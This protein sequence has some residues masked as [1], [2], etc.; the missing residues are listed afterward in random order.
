[1]DSGLVLEVYILHLLKVVLTKGTLLSFLRSL[2]F[3]Y[4]EASE[5]SSQYSRIVL[6][7]KITLYSQILK[8]RISQCVNL[9]AVLDESRLLCGLLCSYEQA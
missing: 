8:A 4:I 5:I 9:K 2:G 1:M 7:A 6:M 3:G